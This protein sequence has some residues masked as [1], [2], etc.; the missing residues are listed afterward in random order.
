MTLIRRAKHFYKIES[1]NA[2]VEGFATTRRKKFKNQQIVEH[3]A[4]SVKS[5]R[6]ALL[7][8]KCVNNWQSDVEQNKWRSTTLKS[9]LINSMTESS[10]SINERQ[11]IILKRKAI[12]SQRCSLDNDNFASCHDQSS[13]DQKM[14][15]SSRNVSKH[16]QGLT[17]QTR[18]FFFI[19]SIYGEIRK[20][21]SDRRRK[22]ASSISAFFPVAQIDGQDQRIMSLS[23][24]FSESTLRA[25]DRFDTEI[26]NQLNPT[27]I[28]SPTTTGLFI[29]TSISAAKILLDS[30]VFDSAA[31]QLL[32]SLHAAEAVS[33]P[34]ATNA[35]SFPDNDIGAAASY[36]DPTSSQ[37]CSRK[38][39]QRSAL[40]NGIEGSMSFSHD[41][42]RNA[43]AGRVV[44]YL[45]SM[46]WLVLQVGLLCWR[47]FSRNI[48]RA[49]IV[50]RSLTWLP[51]ILSL[52][53][54]S[55]LV[56]IC[57]MACVLLIWIVLWTL[58]SS[59]SAV[60]VTTHRLCQW[61]WIDS[62]CSYGCDGSLML[63]CYMF[64]TI[65]AHYLSDENR[66]VQLLWE[67]D[68]DFS[69]H[70]VGNIP[71]R[72]AVHQI[73]CSYFTAQVS[74]IRD[75]M[76]ISE[77]DKKGLLTMQVEMCFYVKNISRD[78]PSYYRHVN[79]F[80]RFVLHQV[81]ATQ[82]HIH[83]ALINSTFQDLLMKQKMINNHISSILVKWQKRY[84]FLESSGQYVAQEVNDVVDKA[85]SLLNHLRKIRGKT[86]RVKKTIIKT[87]NIARRTGRV[88]DLLRSDSRKFDNYNDAFEGLNAWIIETTSF[89]RV[90]I[91]IFNNVTDVDKHMSD[92]TT[93]KLSE[94]TQ[95]QL[96]FEKLSELY[97]YVSGLGFRVQKIRK[98][99][100]D[101]RVIQM[102]PNESNS[103]GFILS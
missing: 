47:I 44:R 18:S 19:G 55:I 27:L 51:L 64:F 76:A 31:S 72:L 2:H 59:V 74:Q 81:N 24:G 40:A 69:S 49:R 83:N 46:P 79:I 10:D 11:T 82:R 9:I 57:A 20:D 3:V 85:T 50:L 84:E 28:V 21:S 92:L 70:A 97:S 61:F 42:P 62:I 29:L 4:M 86:L 13:I 6:S 94:N 60:N 41:V 58:S 100:K 89:E 1:L 66:R 30:E 77:E 26:N 35:S 90:L 56:L 68:I 101:A 48:A 34:L 80:F 53:I 73:S 23:I 87:W 14:I 95:F 91:L 93:T 102:K 43:Q 75:E 54:I 37:A 39:P 8:N 15:G 71:R 38:K 33:L 98:N 67:K 65:C 36:P 7:S 32:G 25:R 52:I 16:P 103:E 63:V 22:S 17:S 99:V 78:L 96:D 45:T 5:I 88:I 12:V